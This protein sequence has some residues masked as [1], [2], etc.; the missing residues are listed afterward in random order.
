MKRGEVWNANL[1]PVIGREQAGFRPVLVVSVDQFNAGPSGLV[2]VLPI[3]SKPRVYFIPS[4]VEVRPPEGGLRVTSYVI[5]EQVRTVSSQRLKQRLGV[6]SG[7]TM[8]LV[9][10]NLRSLLGL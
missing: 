6:L 1:D 5:C 2:S 4:R 9:E 8:S 10:D 3:T 7:N